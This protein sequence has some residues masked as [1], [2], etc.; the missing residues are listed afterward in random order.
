MA[1]ATPSLPVDA[2]AALVNLVVVLADTKVQLGRRLSDWIV[3]AP[4]L[5]SGVACAAIAAEELGTARVLYPLLGDPP[6][7]GPVPL[8]RETDR[9]RRYSP[10]FLDEA[11]PTWSH[12]VAALALIDSA[13]TVV[14]EACRESSDSGLAQR[15]ARILDE[16][17][18]HAAFTDGRLA[19]TAAYP[20][21]RTLLEER[22]RTLLPEMLLWFGP[23]GEP[24]VAA[25]NRSGVLR[26][27][28]EELRQSWLA[29][30]APGLE[31]SGVATSLT[32]NP[33]ERGWRYPDLPWE[34]WNTL[35]RRIEDRA[36]IRSG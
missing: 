5:E 10:R 15:A 14:F 2:R 18:H 23:D 19:E 28:N 31:R 34:R 12:V 27:H 33:G 4:A 16:E 32:Q 17:R 22:V 29:R 35:E 24:G 3:R 9:A 30:V 21:E 13:L 1:D 7:S 36:T 20:A 8:V 25:L 26:G 11:F 6:G